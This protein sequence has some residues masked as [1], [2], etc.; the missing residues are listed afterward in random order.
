[1]N[2]FR[3]KK[4]ARDAVPD[5]PLRASTD[6]EGPPPASKAP[7]TF[8]LGGKKPQEPEP[9]PEID[10]STAL[11]SSDDFRTSLLM[12]GLSARFSMLREQ[13]DPTSKIGKASDD[14][15]LFPKHQSR[16]N[17]FNFSSQGLSDIAEVASINDSIRPPFACGRKDSFVGSEEYASDADSMHGSIMS[18]G[19]PGEGNNLFGG[20]QKIMMGNRALYDNDVS[21]STFR[22][23]REREKEHKEQ[24]RLREEL[25][26][27]SS[28][29]SSPPL[30]GYNRNRETSSTTS[31]AGPSTTRSSTAATSFTSQ[32]TPSLSGSQAPITPAI[33]SNSAPEKPATKTRRLYETGLDNHLHEQQF[34]AMSRID[35]LTRQRTLGANTPPRGHSP[36]H[37]QAPADKWE[38][39]L[40]RKQSLTSFHTMSPPLSGAALGKFDFGVRKNSN[41]D[42]RPYGFAAPPLSPPMTEFDEQGVLSVEPN[43]KGKATASGAFSRPAPFDDLKYSERQLQMQHGRATSPPR[44]NSLPQTFVFRQQEQQ[45]AE[46]RTRAEPSYA[47]ATGRSRSNSSA[48]GALISHDHNRES[49][50]NEPS[51]S[52]Y[53]TDNSA[54]SLASPR[55]M[56]TDHHSRPTHHPEPLDLSRTFRQDQGTRIERPDESQHPANRQQSNDGAA[57]SSSAFSSDLQSETA[58]A[59]QSTQQ[60]A[61]SPLFPETGLSGLVRS[62][63]RSDSNTSFAY[64]GREPLPHNEYRAG[65][66][67]WENEHWDQ[68]FNQPPPFS[69][70]SP[71]LER[72]GKASWGR[73]M[74]SH[75]TRDGSSE[76]QKEAEEFANELASRK[77]RVQEKMQS[78]HEGE[79]R[80][81]SPMPPHPTDFPKEAHQAKNNALGLLKTKTSIGSLV[82]RSKDVGSF[83]P[84]KMLGLGNTSNIHESTSSRKPRFENSPS[85]HDREEWEPARG[86]DSA[87]LQAGAFRE[88]RR[89]AQRDRERAMATR[90]QQR[91]ALEGDQQWPGHRN[92]MERSRLPYQR[93]DN[94]W[95]DNTKM[96]NPHMENPR[97]ENSRSN[98]PMGDPRMDHRYRHQEQGGRVAPHM[99][100]RHR[101]PSRER[102]HPPVAYNHRNGNYTQENGDSNGTSYSGSRPP[103]NA[104]SNT[105]RDRSESDTSGGYTR[106][107]N[108]SYRDDLS[109]AMT[110]STSQGDSEDRG[111]H[112]STR[113]VTTA[114]NATGAGFSASRSPLPSSKADTNRPRSNSKPI[115]SGYLEDS[116][117]QKT[118]E[119]F[120]IGS[121]RR[122]SPPAPFVLHATPALVQ[123]SPSL[124]G[125]STPSSQ[126]S[127]GLP[128]TLMHKK[129]IYKSDISEPKFLSS[130]SNMSAANMPPLQNG[131]ELNVPPIPPVN[132]KRRQTR[133]IFGEFRGRR[134]DDEIHSMPAAAHSTEEM[135]NFSADEGDSKAK[136]TIRTKLR[137]SIS[138]KGSLNTRARQVAN[139][140]PS[141]AL[142]TAFSHGPSPSTRPC[143]GA[144]F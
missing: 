138:E 102:K 63:L 2:R 42:T 81:T 80:S 120:E 36:T 89:A 133:N 69:T 114:P 124:S 131:T 31:S 71:S 50:T 58:H 40:N 119:G 61:E 65:N 48:Q 93:K 104:P 87:A 6:S 107:P 8:R 14:S 125:T 88:A 94:S 5:G 116:S 72:A 3:A 19:K 54:T 140:P 92:E 4:K 103:S 100:P 67:S 85:S 49:P 20:R 98:N 35:S 132:P 78:F 143:E 44:K 74:Q 12:S 99:K 96:N 45:Q 68:D 56:E 105:S 7:K 21:Q 1:M 135:S 111:F 129:S 141:P 17:D 113:I 66:L 91:S 128:G 130:T 24:E 137:K 15:V 18:R 51:L 95:V 70:R 144:M 59:T 47:Y 41:A 76:T 77:R 33:P 29:P 30:S 121:F 27:E 38:R 53:Q 22:K 139:A 11:P 62:H 10:L 13:D 55:D 101:T 9:K 73:E 60:P 106:G 16:F 52:E 123:P 90:H 112:P 118:T 86:P 79:S 117:L 136:P 110:Q 142:P 32:R 64:D 115:S 97:A 37:G 83:K 46:N 26:A 28:R 126:G 75:H 25:E 82:G 108:G 34:S 84:M 57:D 23:I 43:D 127:Q 109:N 134:D 122:P 39:P